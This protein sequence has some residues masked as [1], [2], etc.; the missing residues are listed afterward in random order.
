MAK[1]AEQLITLLNS[2]T[3]TLPKRQMPINLTDLNSYHGLDN[4]HTPMGHHV[5]G[6]HNKKRLTL[7]CT[8]LAEFFETLEPCPANAY[9]QLCNT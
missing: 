8:I 7:A 3:S 5:V 4:F 2:S 6:P 9:H 1:Q